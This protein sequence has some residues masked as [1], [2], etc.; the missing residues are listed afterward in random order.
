MSTIRGGRI[1]GATIYSDGEQ[2]S[3]VEF[4][5]CRID[6]AAAYEEGRRPSAYVGCSFERC[7]GG[8]MD[9]LGRYANGSVH[10]KSGRTDSMTGSVID[11]M[12]R[13]AESNHWKDRAS[14]LG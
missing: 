5:D 6:D 3:G 2:F 12:K 9:D 11:A 13:A 1:Q 4:V 14:P 7:W 8:V 10:V